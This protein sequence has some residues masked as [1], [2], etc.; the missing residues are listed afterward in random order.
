MMEE[1]MQKQQSMELKNKELTFT[2]SIEMFLES[3]QE[4]LQKLFSMRSFT[5]QEILNLVT[6]LEEELKEAERQEIS[7]YLESAVLWN[8][9]PGLSRYT[10]DVGIS[11]VLT[12]GNSTSVLSTLLSTRSSS[13]QEPYL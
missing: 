9:P 3:L 13:Q 7:S 2:P 10:E 12:A 1:L 11:L 8:L 4:I 6:F 5:E